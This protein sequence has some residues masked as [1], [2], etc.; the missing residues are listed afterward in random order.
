MRMDSDC[1]D[2]LYC[3]ELLNE[4]DRHRQCTSIG[5][6]SGHS[7]WPRGDIVLGCILALPFLI[8]SL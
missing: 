1:Q 2:M 7:W 6:S 4:G 3:G 8:I 5:Q